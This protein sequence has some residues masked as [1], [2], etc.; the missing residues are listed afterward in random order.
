MTNNGKEKLTIAVIS[1][2]LTAALSIPTTLIAA[3]VNK[4]S[5]TNVNIVL[6]D[7]QSIDAAQVLADHAELESY[8]A[9]DAEQANAVPEETLPSTTE[10]TILVSVT[11]EGVPLFESLAKNTA[12]WNINNGI[13]KDGWEREYIPKNFVIAVAYDN[14]SSYAEYNLEKRFTT[15]KGT[16]APY[17]NMRAYDS[18]ELRI[19]V[20]DK[21]VYQLTGIKNTDSPVEFICDKLNHA[22]IIQIVV[23]GGS[24][25]LMDFE[26][27]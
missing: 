17:L 1:I 8:R 14:G 3:R 15:V 24:L 19:Y 4:P 27:S 6:P 23:N 13:P 18:G 21:L 25:L 26:L 11:D 22:E 10:T 2:V 16:I 5:D 7:G 9:R 20:N 12:R